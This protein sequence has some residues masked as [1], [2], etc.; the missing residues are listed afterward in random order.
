MRLPASPRCLGGSF[1][2]GGT[3][4]AR[5]RRRLGDARSLRKEMLWV[6]HGIPHGMGCCVGWVQHG[7]L[8]LSGLNPVLRICQSPPAS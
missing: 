2:G 4:R 1:V 7:S 8:A 5:P 3:G 6:S